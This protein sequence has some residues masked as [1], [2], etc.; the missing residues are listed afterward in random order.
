M[1]IP[2]HDDEEWGVTPDKVI[3]LGRKEREDLAEA[4]HNAEIIQ[5]KDRPSKAGNKPE[6][7]DRQL[8][9]ALE[10]LRDQIKAAARVQG[11]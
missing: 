2:G 8:D 5:R 1:H 6:F 4:Q 11:K 3:K 10:Y 7:K 9:A